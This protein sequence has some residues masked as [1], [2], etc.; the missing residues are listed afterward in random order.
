MISTPTF[1]MI[2]ALQRCTTSSLTLRWRSRRKYRCFKHSPRSRLPQLS[3]AAQ[4]RT[5]TNSIPTTKSSTGISM[6]SIP[7]HNSFRPST[8]SCSQLMPPRTVH[9]HYNLKIYFNSKV[10]PKRFA[11]LK[12]ST[13]RPSFG[14]VADWP[15]LSVYLVKALEL[16]L[17]RLQPQV[18]CSV[19]EFT[20]L[21]CPPNQ[22]TTASRVARATLESCFCARLH[23]VIWAKSFMRT[24]MPATFLPACTQP[25]VWAALPQTPVM[26]W[27]W[28]TE[29]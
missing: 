17:P 4:N 23:W 1:L 8:S 29:W 25:K 3:S 16:H 7:N 13:T 20:L 6:R 18:I 2:L 21:T 14:T 10:K 15:T 22:P 24:T 26:Q 9:I 27:S 12:T 28:V 19:R 5:K 11:T